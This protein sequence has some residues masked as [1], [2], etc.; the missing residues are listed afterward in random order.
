[1]RQIEGE[2]MLDLAQADEQRRA[3]DKVGHLRMG[4]EIDNAAQLRRLRY[5]I[6]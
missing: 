6:V 2:G 5:Q 4:D 3:G 1:M